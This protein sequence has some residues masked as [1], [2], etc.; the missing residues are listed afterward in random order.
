[1]NH[2]AIQRR[3]AAGAKHLYFERRA[4][5]AKRPRRKIHLAACAAPL[6]PQLA[7]ACPFP[8]M[9][10]LRCNDGERSFAHDIGAGDMFAVLLIDALLKILYSRTLLSG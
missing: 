1:M 6:Q 8:E 4:A 10:G 9:P 2:I 7:G 3:P 5:R